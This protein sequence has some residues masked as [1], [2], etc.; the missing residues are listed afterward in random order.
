MGSVTPLLK[1]IARRLSLKGCELMCTE[2]EDCTGRC[3]HIFSSRSA[4]R[5]SKD[6][7]IRTGS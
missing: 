1:D 5:G 7:V 2:T 4:N 3:G 6:L